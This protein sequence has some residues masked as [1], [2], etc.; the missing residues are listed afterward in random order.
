MCACE[1]LQACG[2]PGG[3]NENRGWGQGVGGY[4]CHQPPAREQLKGWARCHTQEVSQ[5]HVQR[6]KSA[7]PSAST[8]LPPNVLTGDFFHFTSKYTPQAVWHAIAFLKCRLAWHLTVKSRWNVKATL[9][10]GFHE[11]APKQRALPA[12]RA[13]SAQPSA[14]GSDFVAGRGYTCPCRVQG[15][16][17]P[18]AFSFLRGQFLFF[19]VR[20]HKTSNIE[21]SV[22][23]YSNYLFLFNQ[24][25]MWP[26]LQ[27]ISKMVPWTPQENSVCSPP[28]FL[29]LFHECA[30]SNSASTPNKNL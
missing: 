6:P 30:E 19:S 11:T 3:P 25:K 13:R 12:A 27:W 28:D 1:W 17:V 21:I 23:F 4:T 5:L 9:V 2:T 10:L 20:T 14:L 8:S 22:P 26:T 16:G 15:L 24:V 18:L 7:F 29:V